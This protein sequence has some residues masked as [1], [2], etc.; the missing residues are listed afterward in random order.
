VRTELGGSVIAMRPMR[1]DDIGRAM[2]LVRMAGWNQTEPDWRMML[3]AG[4]GYG[5]GDEGGRLLASSMVLPYA[6]GI[7]WIGMVLVDEAARRRGLATRLLRNAIGRIEEAGLVPMLDA[8]PAGREVYLGLGFHDLDGISRWRGVGGLSAPAPADGGAPM[9]DAAADAGIGADAENF[10]AGRRWLLDDLRSRP[11]ALALALPAGDGWLWSRAGRTATQ[12]GPVLSSNPDNAIA[13]CGAA[14]D[15][16]AGPVLL[17]VP[18]RETGLA[19]FLQA[20]GFTIER[21]LMRM[22]RGNSPSTLG[23]SMRVIAGP[24]L[25]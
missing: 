21:S 4:G 20:R 16:I 18:D 24:E 8:T 2:E 23:G 17:D 12:I 13:L 15:R 9:D 7:G 10:G 3:A 19:S 11:G 5:I 6:P 1:P 14:L 22:A 25:G